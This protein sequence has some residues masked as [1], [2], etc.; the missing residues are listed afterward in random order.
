MKKIIKFISILLFVISA[1]A[2]IYYIYWPYAINFIN[3]KG[4]TGDALMHLANI[5][6]FKRNHPFPLMAWKTEWGG[7]PVIE[8]YPWLHY[9]LI[10]PFLN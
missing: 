4:I 1:V 8:G 10:Q 9:Y 6:S 3:A 7:Y 2:L 5:I